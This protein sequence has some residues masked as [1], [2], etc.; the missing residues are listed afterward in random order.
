MS[1]NS[2]FKRAK[3]TPAE[4]QARLKDEIEAFEK[5]LKSPKK[6]QMHLRPKG[7]TRTMG[8]DLGREAVKEQVKER[9][10]E[11]D[12][13]ESRRRQRERSRDD[14]FEM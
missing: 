4:R 6:P 12:A 11:L 13:M 10:E 3:E 7:M 2:D 8:D 1:M 9:R 5:E 14:D